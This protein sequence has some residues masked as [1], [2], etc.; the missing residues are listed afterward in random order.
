MHV[1]LT[2]KAS[3]QFCL[4]ISL[5]KSFI[6]RLL[7]AGLSP[8]SGFV[9]GSIYVRFVDKVALGQVLQF[10]LVSIISL[11]LSILSEISNYVLYYS[12]S[13]HICHEQYDTDC[14]QASLTATTLTKLVS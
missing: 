12:Q 13:I 8:R 9:P 14:L 1:Q 6:G 7:V 10:S 2:G 11:W 3:S 5:V 4:C